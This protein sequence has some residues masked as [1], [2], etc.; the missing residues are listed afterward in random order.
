M[1]AH[2]IGR[3]LVEKCINAPEQVMP[4]VLGRSN[5]WL[6]F[7]ESFLRVTIAEEE[8]ALVVVTVTVRRRRPREGTR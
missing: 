5:Y 2:A 6:R 7:G 3:D 4:S 8:D 1:R